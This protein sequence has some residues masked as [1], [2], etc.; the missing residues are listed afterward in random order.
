M[1]KENSINYMY[2]TVDIDK[3]SGIKEYV[4][5]DVNLFERFSLLLYKKKYNYNNIK[6]SWVMEGDGK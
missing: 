1:N 2:N 3:I 5:N 4:F 6:S